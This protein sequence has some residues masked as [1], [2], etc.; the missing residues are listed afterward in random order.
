MV[1]SHDDLAKVAHRH[2]GF[3]IED[4]ELLD[5]DLEFS[6]RNWFGDDHSPW[7]AFGARVTAFAFGRTH[8]ELASRQRHH[9]GA[10]RAIL[11]GRPSLQVTRKVLDEAKK[12][13]ISGPHRPTGQV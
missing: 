7:Q 10:L 13:R 6:D 8:H 4:G 12:C 1:K 2:S 5:C 3:G 9:L 11:E